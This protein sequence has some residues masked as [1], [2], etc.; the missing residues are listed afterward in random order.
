M[1][2]RRRHHRHRLAL[3]ARLVP[4]GG[5]GFPVEVLNISAEAV[6]VRGPYAFHLLKRALL[7]LHLGERVFETDSVCVRVNQGPPW[8][9]AFLFTNPPEEAL[10]A[11]ET[12]LAGL[13]YPQP[14]G[15]L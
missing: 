1:L 13:P 4:A 5:E 14:G 15:A 2:E 9:G 7:R 8:E 3:P 12:F 6:L 11:L 10:R